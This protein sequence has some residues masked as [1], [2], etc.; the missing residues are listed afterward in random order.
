MDHIILFFS[1]NMGKLGTKFPLS[2]VQKLGH[3]LQPKLAKTHI[4]TCIFTLE[5]V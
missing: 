3:F 4:L 1:I 5:F 2:G